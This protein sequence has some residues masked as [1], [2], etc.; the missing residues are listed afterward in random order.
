MEIPKQTTNDNFFNG[1]LK[2]VD[3]RLDRKFV[4]FLDKK[5]VWGRFETKVM[6]MIFLDKKKP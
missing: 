1:G 4:I 5:K 3:S 6:L 2:E